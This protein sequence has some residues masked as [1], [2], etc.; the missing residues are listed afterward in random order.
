[1]ADATQEILIKILTAYDKGGMDAVSAELKKL[2]AEADQ[3]SGEMEA[4]SR[5][6]ANLAGTL[7]GVSSAASGSSEGIFRVAS[8]IRTLLGAIDPSIAKGGLL[9]ATFLASY[10]ATRKF[11]DALSGGKE[12]AGKFADG[13]QKVRDEA[14]ALA[15]T[16]LDDIIGQYRESADEIDRAAQAHERLNAARMQLMDAKTAAKIADV[17]LQEKKALAG[18]APDDEIGRSRVR[19]KYQTERAG[20]Q[21]AAAAERTQAELEMASQSADMASRKADAAERAV[22]RLEGEINAL[23]NS[24]ASKQTAVSDVRA[25]PPTRAQ[26]VTRLGPGGVPLKIGERTVVDQEK[27]DKMIRDLNAQITRDA[28]AAAEM[29]RQLEDARNEAKTLRSKAEAA[30]I[31]AQA[32][33]VKAD[34]AKTLPAASAAEAEA[35]TKQVDHAAKQKAESAAKDAAK[36]QEQESEIREL[37]QK[38]SE[39]QGAINVLSGAE[40]SVENA[41]GSLESARSGLV[42]AKAGSRRA[43]KQSFSY[44]P[45]AAAEQNYSTAKTGLDNSVRN[46]ARLTEQFGGGLDKLIPSMANLVARIKKLETAQNWGVE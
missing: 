32:A 16:K 13:L 8:G 31:G 10:T 24:V 22:V 18:V 39:L 2:N 40:M 3:S 25:N 37:R 14:D 26:D 21:D 38:V 4:A 34:T 6:A 42:S 30:G 15:Q 7:Q 35:V 28:A 5:T 23:K 27:A 1:M 36:R 44:A 19:L 9:V 33:A 43:S 17:D 46:L 20:I 29:Q 12:D 11:I 45:V 41:E